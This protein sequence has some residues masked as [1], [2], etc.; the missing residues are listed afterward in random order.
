MPVTY[1][2]V[3]FLIMLIGIPA[4][5]RLAS[6]LL[7]KRTLVAE[8]KISRATCN[9]A[10]RA[11][12][13]LTAAVTTPLSFLM[14]SGLIL[15]E[16]QIISGNIL[17]MFVLGGIMLGFLLLPIYALV[18]KDIQNLDLELKEVEKESTGKDP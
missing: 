6:C 9:I 1:T 4:F 15:K 5:A 8:G 13:K 17:V 2:L 10:S 14:S 3:L 16:R 7:F 12:M 18:G 11:F